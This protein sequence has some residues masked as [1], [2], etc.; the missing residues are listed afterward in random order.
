MKLIVTGGFGVLGRLLY[1]HLHKTYDVYLLDRGRAQSE[2]I[3]IDQADNSWTN[4]QIPEDHYYE[5]DILDYD[6]VKEALK[7]KD[8]VVHLAALLENQTSERIQQVNVD[9]TKNILRA[10][11]ENNVKGLVYASSIMVMYSHREDPVINNIFTG[12]KD[13]SVNL[14]K[15]KAED[16][17]PFTK[18]I[19]T[20]YF[21]PNDVEGVYAYISSKLQCEALIK[22]F[23]EHEKDFSAI[24]M[25]L[26]WVNVMDT[27]FIDIYNPSGDESCVWLSQRDAKTFMQ[28]CIEAISKQGNVCKT[29]F[30]ISANKKNWVDIETTKKEIGFEPIDKAEDLRK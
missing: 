8:I 24:L 28:K 3:V 18:E 29:Y 4:P 26:G 30:G 12:D 2:R 7:D 13:D 27:P 14:V 21:A 22:E 19:V 20:K 11:R 16:A 9:G 10:C 1:E 6:R 25:R 15:R 5:C 23:V 17:I